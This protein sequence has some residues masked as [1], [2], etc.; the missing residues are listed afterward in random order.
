M[1]DRNQRI[2]EIKEIFELA[3]S[4]KRDCND[5]FEELNLHMEVGDILNEVGKLKLYELKD[6][7]KLY[8]SNKAADLRL[9]AVKTLGWGNRLQIPEFQPL[10][11]SLWLGDPDE[12]VRVAALAA[13]CGYSINTQNIIMLKELYEVLISRDH[14]IRIRTYA[15]HCIML[16][17]G[18]YVDARESYEILSLSGMSG[19]EIFENGV[20]WEQIRRVMR[21]CMPNCGV[22]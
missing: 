6:E 22:C 11:H 1:L 21:E 12:E 13:W 17:A 2:D 4:A 18:A 7:V 5:R 14:S 10:A 8:L 19:H 20:K 16:V 15:L 9:E 3:K